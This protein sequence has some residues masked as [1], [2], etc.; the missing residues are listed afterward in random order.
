MTTTT[1][2]TIVLIVSW[3]LLFLGVFIFERFDHRLAALHVQ[4]ERLLRMHEALQKHLGI[5][6]PAD[7][8][9]VLL[10]E[11]VQSGKTFEAIAA[12]RSARHASYKEAKAYVDSL[13]V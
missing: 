10:R 5:E 8:F 6:M 1:T 2:L 4:Q 13:R 9:E 7:D 12:Y 3:L 11:L